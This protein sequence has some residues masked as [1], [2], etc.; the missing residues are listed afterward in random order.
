[1]V[2][3]ETLCECEKESGKQK[4]RIKLKHSY[5]DTARDDIVSAWEWRERGL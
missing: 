3:K 4:G 2:L 1:V 5:E